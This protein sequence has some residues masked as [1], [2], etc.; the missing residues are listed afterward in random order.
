MQFY[1]FRSCN[2]IYEYYINHESIDSWFTGTLGLINPRGCAF[3]QRWMAVAPFSRN[4]IAFFFFKKKKWSGLKHIFCDLLHIFSFECFSKLEHYKN[5]PIIPNF[6]KNYPL[7][8]IDGAYVHHAIP[9]RAPLQP[10][11]KMGAS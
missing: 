11:S 5:T 8:K 1:S 10:W 9:F 3:L 2:K 7:S 6:L 4:F